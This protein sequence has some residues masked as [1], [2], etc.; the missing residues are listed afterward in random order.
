MSSSAEWG[1]NLTG[2]CEHEMGQHVPR[3]SEQVTEKVSRSSSALAPLEGPPIT[4]QAPL[5]SFP[6]ELNAGKDPNQSTLKGCPFQKHRETWPQALLLPPPLRT[7]PPTTRAFAAPLQATATGQVQDPGVGNAVF[8][9]CQPTWR[10]RRPSQWCP[11]AEAHLGCRSDK[12]SLPTPPRPPHSWDLQSPL[13]TASEERWWQVSP[14]EKNCQAESR[15]QRGQCPSSASLRGVARVKA[16]H[17]RLEPWGRAEAEKRH[18]L[19]RGLGGERKPDF[20]LSSAR[21]MRLGTS[22]YQDAGTISHKSTSRTGQPAHSQFR[23][24]LSKSLF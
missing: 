2:P 5:R 19:R 9:A 3:A 24:T 1:Q 4:P 8:P 11:Q 13:Q 17:R 23:G 7:R 15:H 21:G 6:F 22:H 10:G 14:G 12:A 18:T 16:S 20:A